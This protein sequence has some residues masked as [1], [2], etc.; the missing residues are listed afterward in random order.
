MGNLS[1]R[2]DLVSFA[3]TDSR[4]APSMVTTYSCLM[5]LC[6][7][8]VASP[9]VIDLPVGFEKVSIYAQSRL[10]IRSG[11]QFPCHVEWLSAAHSHI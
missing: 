2:S 8:R 3:M 1:S 5:L 6:A 10:T 7:I 9:F 4:N 11:I